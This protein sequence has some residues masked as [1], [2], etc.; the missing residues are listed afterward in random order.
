MATKIPRIKF[1]NS[2]VK[3][4][5]PEAETSSIGELFINANAERPF[6]STKDSNG[7]MKK[8]I[9]EDE[10]NAYLEAE[11]TA[12][13]NAD[14][15]LQENLDNET[16]ARQDADNTLTTNLAN[17]VYRAKKSEEALGNRIT[18]ET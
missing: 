13:K 7:D 15:E 11:A 6:I 14:D 4:K 12:R 16:K 3:N 17:E 1:F 10:I 9:F 2:V 18:D 8:V 5:M